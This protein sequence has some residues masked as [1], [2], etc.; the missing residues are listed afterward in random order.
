MEWNPVR[1]ALFLLDAIVRRA[2]GIHGLADDPHCLFRVALRASPH[3]CRLSDETV[4]HAGD[5]II[6][7]HL[8]N[9]RV[10]RMPVN[11]PDLKWARTFYER[12]RYSLRVLAEAVESDPH[13]REAVAVYGRLFVHLGHRDPTSLLIRRL[14]F[15]IRRVPEPDTLPARVGRFFVTLYAGWLAWAYNPGSLQIQDIWHKDLVEVWM[16]RKG[17]LALYGA[18]SQHKRHERPAGEEEVSS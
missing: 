10:P 15:E 14:G 5:P 9:E 17:L 7:L 6:E 3:D 1:W 16:S 18:P 8:W 2:S 12:L 11:G 4:V 13:L